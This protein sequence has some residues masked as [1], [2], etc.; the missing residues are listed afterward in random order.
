[1]ANTLKL[2]QSAVASKVPTTAQLQLGELAVN[3]YDG[4]LFTKKNV[5]GTESVVEFV[6][7][8]GTWGI[9]INGNAATVGG[10]SI[11]TSG[12]TIPLLDAANTW[13]Q[14]QRMPCLCSDDP[15]VS[16]HVIFRDLAQYTASS[17]SATATGALVIVLGRAVSVGTLYSARIVITGAYQREIIVEAGGY[18]K[19]DNTWA[20][21][22]AT[23]THETLLSVQFARTPEGWPC[24][25][26]A[27]NANPVASAWI[28]Y[29]RC[30][31]D[32]LTLG[33]YGADSADNLNPAYYTT[34]LVTDLTNY[35]LGPSVVPLLFALPGSGGT[36][37][38]N[39]TAPRLISNVAQG[40]AP[41]GVTSTTVCTKL[42]AD[43]LDGYHVGTSGGTIPLLN[44]ANTWSGAQTYQGA[45]MRFATPAGTD[46]TAISQING[47]QVY[48][49]TDGADALMT[50][51]V[52]GDYAFH[53][54]LD[55]KTN[56]LCVGGWS[57]GATKYQIWHEGNQ[58][59]S[60]GLNAD[61]LDG[62]HVGTSGDTIPLLNAANTW[63]NAQTFTAN[64]FLLAH[65]GTNPTVM[66]RQGATHFFL[67]LSDAGSA[68]SSIYNSLRPFSVD[69]TTGAVTIGNGLTATLTGNASTATTLQTA[70][71][72]N[73]TSFNGSADITTA[74]WGTTRTLTIGNT[75]K[76]VDGS[77]AVTWSLAEIGALPV[78]GGT[79]TGALTI[80]LGTVGTGLAL[81]NC[82]IV[83]TGG[84]VSAPY[85]SADTVTINNDP[86]QPS[87]A[88]S[89]TYVDAMAAKDA[90]LVAT[91]NPIPYGVFDSLTG[92]I[93]VT[94]TPFTFTSV[95]SNTITLTGH[96]FNTGDCIRLDPSVQDASNY[97]TINGT[98]RVPGN[99]ANWY[100]IKVDAN[101]IKISNTLGSAM[102]GS[103]LSITITGTV[104]VTAKIPAVIDAQS[105]SVGSRVL[106]R[107]QTS[108]AANGIYEVADNTINA[109]SMHRSPDADTWG[110][111]S[112][113]LVPVP[114][115][116]VNNDSLWICTNGST[117]TINTTAVA[118]RALATANVTYGLP[119]STE[120]SISTTGPISA[121]RF[122]RDQGDPATQNTAA[123]LTSTQVGAGILQ[124]TPTAPITLTLP[125]GTTMEEIVIGTG[126]AYDLSI[127]N[128]SANAV[129]IAANT[130]HTIVGSATIAANTS[131]LWCFR[132]TAANTFIAY[133]I[134]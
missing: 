61:L 123:T 91:F 73:G 55:G 13:S 35:T 79:L 75:G 52:A 125:T 129:T 107:S 67:L 22:F 65:N 18:F 29:I 96:Q 63:S 117:G 133:R 84:S 122:I 39:I 23:S 27:N 68:P 112:G 8:S 47:L 24:V 81:S 116:T 28:S 70:R 25:I 69:L 9:S 88:T 46:I 12:N 3:T 95:S 93:A 40:T 85:I 130:G 34:S 11:G 80:N 102:S 33:W 32:T 128:T 6:S 56:K 101:N 64:T 30:R 83:V 71:N 119:Y 126:E 48:Q 21:V 120:P 92:T 78:A 86:A 20:N 89:K 100:V 15:A 76:S 49:A 16:R 82:D 97:L 42:N 53:F 57:M 72:I 98:A 41:I 108:G 59:V 44:A 31:I 109:W 1:M 37:T 103:S 113:A 4:R 43:L 36:L 87:D 74:S 60:S 111:L 7:N 14:V 121:S 17:I 77:A 127:I 105:L 99:T 26:L 114:G 110:A 10:K 51:H 131:S 124:T 5:S 132:K 94:Y 19:S 118:F 50:F 134:S 90:C 45:V 66:L 38:G 2:K 58:G 104:T 115:G 62:Y 106:V 54:G